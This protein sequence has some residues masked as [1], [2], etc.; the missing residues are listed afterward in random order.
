MQNRIFLFLAAALLSA[1]SVAQDVVFPQLPGYKIK[2]GYPVYEPG[3]LW[4]FINGAADNYLTYGFVDLHVAEYKKGKA[5]IKLEIY[6][7]GSNTMAFGIY[8]SERS[9]S[10][11]FV[12][13]GAQGYIADGSINFFKGDYYVKIRTYSKKEK[14]LSAEEML[15][16]RV[17]SALPGGDAMPSMLLQFPSEGRKANE[18]TYI[19]ESVLGHGF[20]NKAFKAVYQAG[21]DE[22][23][24]YISEGSSPEEVRKTAETYIASTG[25]SVAETG[26]SKFM[27][28][29][30]YN[31][32][33]FLA[34]KD[35]R[36]VIISGL[37]KDQADLA[38][39]YT[40]EILK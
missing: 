40:A 27:I 31:G 30:G 33:I 32:T 16:N 2:T 15:A 6:R 38:D 1:A 22:F 10:F 34:W 39:K 3:N 11:R 4:D 8:S 19:N 18:E 5:V 17:A 24:I 29:D 13:I 14:V 12:D 36:L 37:A 26:D 7:H 21:P 23:A 35:K 9:P 20:L 25:M 28:T